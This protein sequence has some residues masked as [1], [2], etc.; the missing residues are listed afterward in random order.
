MS[1]MS[2][3]RVTTTRGEFLEAM[4][5]AFADAGSEGC[6]EMWICDVDF[7]DWPLSERPVIESLTR[8]AYAHRKLTVL[9]T[10]YEEFHRR[11]ARFVEWRRQ[12]SHVVECRLMDE[13]EPGDMP[14]ILLAPGVVTVRLLDRARFRANVS[15]EPADAVYC[16]EI[17]DA[18]S[19]RSSEAFP[20]TTLGL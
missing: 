19:Q 10:T 6:R 8:W 18:I 5:N 14:S 2:T 9:S 4:R 20:A 15:L 1:L 16:R 12:W 11:H 13:I 3:H 17:V 7:A